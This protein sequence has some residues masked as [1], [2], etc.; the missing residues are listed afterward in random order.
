MHP[1]RSA[2][3]DL[4]L[5]RTH[6]SSAVVSDCLD[7]IGL[8]QQCLGAG[9]HPLEPDQVIAGYAFP[10][11]IERVDDVPEQPFRGLVAA[12]DAIEADEVFVTPTGRATDIAVWG[13]LLSTACQRRGAA[14][15]ITDGL[16]RDI[17]AVRRLG[18]PVAGAGAIPYDSKGRHE[19]VAH[20]VAAVIDGVRIEPGDLIVADVDGV[21]VVPAARAAEIVAAAATKRS[22][23]REFRAA[24]ADGMGATHAFAKFGVL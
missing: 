9:I 10:V 22:I 24:V 11:E 5:I 13:E 15:A 4:E 20:R 18:F 6:L 21:V 17:R 8:R 2:T 16:V 19:V 12:L 3:V 23:E 1:L 7:A 14:G